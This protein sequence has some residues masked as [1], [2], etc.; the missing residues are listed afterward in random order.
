[1]QLDYKAIGLKPPSKIAKMHT[2]S[3]SVNYYI[4]N[5]DGEFL[6]KLIQASQKIS[7]NTLLTNLKQT[8][9]CTTAPHFL[10]EKKWNDYFVLVFQWIEGESIFLE[11]LPE[12]KFNHLI[13]SYLSLSDQMNSGTST[14]ILPQIQLS[15]IYRSI[16]KPPRFLKKD[17]DLIKGELTYQ[18]TRKVIHGDFHYKNML[19]K[20]NKL[21][22]FL[23]FAEFRYGCPTEDLIRLLLTNAEQ[24]K[25]FR[26][27]YTLKLLRLMLKNTP[28]SRQD[29]LYGLDLFVLQ[30]YAKK[31]KK[32]NFKQYIVL[33]RCN[34]L[35]KK[36]RSTI[37]DY[38][39]H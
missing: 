28:Y 11:K 12:S 31:L 39:A 22:S 35:Y 18:P 14:A 30:R 7:K 8:S 20:D 24:H 4:Q 2:G 5:E 10:F 6:I 15:N 16:I 38:F 9:H 33:F 13:Q 19:F 1:M 25:V 26:T 37:N 17:L 34:V 36:I 29:W 21:Q 32:K 23:D 27:T 3:A